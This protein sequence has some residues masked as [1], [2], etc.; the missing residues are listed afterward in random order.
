MRVLK[1]FLRTESGAPVAALTFRETDGGVSLVLPKG[2]TALA[3]R[4]GKGA[5]IPIRTKEGEILSFS[6]M[7]AALLAKKGNA[8]L[9]A[10]EEGGESF[11]FKKWRLLSAIVDATPSEE[12]METSEISEETEDQEAPIE[13]PAPI[14]QAAPVQ[15]ADPPV[16]AELEQ[17][18]KLRKIREA[19]DRGEPFPGFEKLIEG[20]KWV[21]MPEEDYLIG[22]LNEDEDPIVLYGVPGKLGEAPDDTCDW[23]FLPASEENE[24][25]GYY[26]CQSSDL[27]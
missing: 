14:E 12:T 4:D 8:M 26:I 5:E 10:F 20:S 25:W 23:T 1:I 21:R 7:P 18:E 22:I 9:Y 13:P 2:V 15:T 19:F 16:E 6:A 3:A 24:D 17:N 11:A 27:E